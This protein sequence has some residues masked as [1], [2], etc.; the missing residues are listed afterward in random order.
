MRQPDPQNWSPYWQRQTLTSFG[1]FFP[2]NYD[3][4][5]LEFWKNE[6]DGSF[7]HIVDVACGNGA[8]SWIANDLLNSGA[9]GSRTTITG[10]DFADISPFKVLRR[11]KKDYPALRF[12]G[13]TPAEELPF[14]DRSIDLVI[15]QYGVEYTNLDETIPEI[16]RVL[17]DAG[18]MSFVLHDKESVIIERATERLD[19]FRKVANEIR[20]H[21]Y[22]LKLDELLQTLSTLAQRQASPEFQARLAELNGAADQVR[23]LVQGY[24]PR[25]PIHLYMERL[26][27]AINLPPGQPKALRTQGILQARDALQAHITRI[28]DLEAAALSA[29]ERKHLTQ[30]IEDQGFTIVE[31]RTLPYR[32]DDNIGTILTARRN[33]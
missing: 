13:N 6:L 20:P 29:A 19:D 9:A 26:N 21:D 2:D 18:R 31:Q 22:A 25:S 14:K 32:D 11:N 24:P 27:Q 4:S 3:D 30:L 17:T 15:S 28:E 7:N 12:I 1:D 10:V 16:A 5:I 33:P 8:L 23:Q